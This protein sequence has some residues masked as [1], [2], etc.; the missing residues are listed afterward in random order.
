MLTLN[1][2]SSVSLHQLDNLMARL[3]GY[4]FWKN[5]DSRY[6]GCNDNFLKLIQISDQNSIINTTD[7]DLP[8]QA[9]GNGAEHFRREDQKT[10]NNYRTTNHREAVLIPGQALKIL[11]VSKRPILQYKRCVGVIGQ[12]IDITSLLLPSL[13]QQSENQIESQLQLNLLHSLTECEKKCLKFIL[14]GYPYK[15]IANKLAL[16]PRTIESHTMR[17]KIKLQC[18]SKTEL[19]E[20]F[21]TLESKMTLGIFYN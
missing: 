18:H 8:W 16:S 5:Q 13:C 6:Q 12:S 3:P 4:C 21:N 17:I 10:M 2:Y 20:K 7:F 14:Q 19:M 1:Q 11:M 15:Y 9:G